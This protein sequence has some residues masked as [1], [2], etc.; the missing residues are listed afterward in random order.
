MS[1]TFDPAA[2]GPGLQLITYTVTGMGCDGMWTD[3]I[4]VFDLPI[5]T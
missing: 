1:F 4:H 3:F 2:A 5:V